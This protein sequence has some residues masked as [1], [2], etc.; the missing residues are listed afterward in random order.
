MEI[1]IYGKI[2]SIRGTTLYIHV[3]DDCKT[4]QPLKTIETGR[5][6]DFD[7]IQSDLADA[8]AGHSPRTTDKTKIRLIK[9]RQVCIWPVVK[10]KS[11][12]C[13]TTY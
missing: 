7:G 13:M 12:I 6:I 3:L 10:T 4:F 11:H 2:Y 5:N 1:T 8:H 9:A